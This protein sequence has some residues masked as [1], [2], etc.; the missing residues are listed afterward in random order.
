MLTDSKL[1]EEYIAKSGLKRTFIAERIG[2][3]R[4]GLWKKINNL[5]AFNQYEIENLCSVLGICTV[6]EKENIFFAQLVD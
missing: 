3:S 6:Q 5:S 2:L 4:S 1:L